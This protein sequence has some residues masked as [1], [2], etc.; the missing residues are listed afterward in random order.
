M[1]RD[2]WHDSFSA[3]LSPRAASAATA[4]FAADDSAKQVSLHMAFQFKPALERTQQQGVAPDCR[5]S[6]KTAPCLLWC[7]WTLAT[8]CDVGAT[9]VDL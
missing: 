4:A 6:L 3:I 1:V 7:G 5:A 2:M 8:R 9:A